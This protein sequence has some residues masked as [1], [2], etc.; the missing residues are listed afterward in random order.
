[1]AEIVILTGENTGK[2]FPLPDIPTVVG[3]SA[4]A[5]VQLTD[6]W[7][8]SMHAMF[9]RRGDEIWVV[10]LDSRNGTFLGE[11]RIAEGRVADGTIVR[12]GRTEVRLQLRAGGGAPAEPPEAAR[13]RDAL[14]HTVR[15]DGTLSTR[16]PLAREREEDPYALA[17]RPATVLRMA[18]DAA[19]IDVLPG[20]PDRLRAALDAAARAALEA[21]GVVTRLAGV[22]VLALFGLS[23]ASPD[24]AVQAIAA[25]RAARRGVRAAGGLDLRAAVESGPVLAGNASG[26]GFELAALGPTAERT[27]RLLARATRGEI[28]AGPGVGPVSGVVRVGLVRLGEADVEVFRAT[29]EHEQG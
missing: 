17:P 16:S 7:I 22:G 5:H 8:S 4:E 21:G 3:R 20:A 11:D 18:V 10:D 29:D 27:E 26:A 23:G 1:M 19:G 13:A 25:A 12:F 15:A 2:V 9:E 14:R 28:L 24:D 6:P